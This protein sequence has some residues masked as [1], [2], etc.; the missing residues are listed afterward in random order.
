MI[1]VPRGTPAQ[2]HID[3]KL[4]VAVLDVV[5]HVGTPFA[6][7]ED[8]L[9]RD[10]VLPKPCGRAARGGN[11]EPHP[12]KI[13]GHGNDPVLVMIV[14]TE[15]DP[16]RKRHLEAGGHLRFR[17]GEAEGMVDSHHLARRLHLGAEQDVRVGKAVEG[18][19][20]LF[21]RDVLRSD[22]FREAELL[23]GFPQHDLRRQLRQRDPD[24]LADEG[25]GP[26]GAGIDLQHV[27]VA[28]LDRIL[29]VH[30]A[31]NVEF[32]GDQLGL[33]LDGLQELRRKG[34]R[35]QHAGAVSG[36]DPR[37]LDMLHDPG[38]DGRLSVADRVHVHLDRVLKELIDQDGV[39]GGDLQRP[40][41]ELPET[42]RIVND[43]H[44][45]PAEDIGR[46]NQDGVADPLGHPDRLRRVH[47]RVVVGL[48]ELETVHDLL[49]TLTVLGAVDR[50][51]G[52]PENRR[53]RRLQTAREVQR[54]LAAE[55]DDDT[56]RFLRLQDVENVLQRHRLEEE[57]VGG[58]V[59]GAH[60]LRVRVDHDALVPLLAKS[61]GG[62]DAAVVE[63]D[64]LA[65]PVRPPA[66]DDHLRL[67]RGAGLVL[68]FV[69]R[70]VV[71]GMGLE[72]RRAG[73]DE[74]VDGDDPGGIAAIPDLL[75]GEV[76]EAAEID[77]GESPPLR[78]IEQPR[79]IGPLFDLLL[80]LDERPD[81]VQEP[82]VDLRQAIDLLDCHPATEGRRDVE[83]AQ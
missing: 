7:L 26:R 83:K 36:M 21:H 68:R 5:D 46:P 8:R 76:P 67:R 45:T 38:D 75:L 29:D 70:V 32:F 59:V 20:R 44:R 17:K 42:L 43:L 47:R 12:G 81:L 35:R 79:R 27:E 25:D 60:G 65:D 54:G 71:G 64:P 3:D 53:P 51:G 56:H 52:G 77:V 49:K 2:A 62:V 30:Q 73:V 22:G 16:P 78:L 48:A 72:L 74:L 37:L 24:C 14:N 31:D 10:P 6:D 69:G 80:R 50:V 66:D 33:P 28:I 18:E 11:P 57:L 15:E 39:A 9:D 4:D 63:L 58:V 34:D 23:Q 61:E 82:G 41:H 13:P 1:G 19:D 40:D 55:L